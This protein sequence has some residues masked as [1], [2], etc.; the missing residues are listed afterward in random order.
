MPLQCL[1]VEEQREAFELRCGRRPGALRLTYEG[2]WRASLDA[3]LDPAAIAGLL[4]PF[5]AH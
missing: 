4:P 3:S 1:E 5:P 2:R